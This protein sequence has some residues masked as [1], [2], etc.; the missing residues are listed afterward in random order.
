MKPAEFK[1]HY[2]AL[3]ALEKE[4]VTQKGDEYANAADR[5]S[6]FRH[7]VALQVPGTTPEGAAWNM[8]SKHLEAAMHGLRELSLGNPPDQRFWNEKLGDIIIYTRLIQIMLAERDERNT[9]PCSTSQK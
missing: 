4:L 7:A 2:S 6:N 8:M 5:F 9:P 3:L 1:R